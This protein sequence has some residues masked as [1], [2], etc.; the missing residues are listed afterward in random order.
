MTPREAF[1][2]LTVVGKEV[3]FTLLV[4]LLWPCSIFL[5]AVAQVGWFLHDGVGSQKA[6]RAVKVLQR[7][8]GEL[9]GLLSYADDPL[10]SLL[11][12]CSWSTCRGS[13]YGC[14]LGWSGKKTQAVSGS[15]SSRGSSGSR[16][17]AE[18]SSCLFHLR[19]NPK[20]SQWPFPHR[21]RQWQC[22]ECLFGRSLARHPVDCGGLTF[23]ILARLRWPTCSY[24]CEWIN[25]SLYMRWLLFTN[26]TK[27]D[28]AIYWDRAGFELPTSSPSSISW[29]DS[30]SFSVDSQLFGPY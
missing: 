16:A 5:M 18:S 13:M 2:E 21:F 14:S 1:I 10:D 8:Q 7:R 9:N 29:T 28:P 17:S 12:L 19:V 3:F 23:P 25:I 30:V 4:L 26:A 15:C 11:P 20:G 6:V 22:A 24:T 27:T